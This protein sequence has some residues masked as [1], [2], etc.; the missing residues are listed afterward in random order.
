MSI[1]GT[2]RPFFFSLTLR[3]YLSPNFN[4]ISRSN[5]TITGRK[6]TNASKVSTQE[7]YRTV[8]NLRKKEK[9]IVGR[10]DISDCNITV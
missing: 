10:R 9:K 8:Q 3:P 7:M 5:K 6:N 1:T 4:S 2:F